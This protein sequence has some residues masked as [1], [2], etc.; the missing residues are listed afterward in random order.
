[1]ARRLSQ[2]MLSSHG[3]IRG[4][5]PWGGGGVLGWGTENVHVP[6]MFTTGSADTTVK[7]EA[8]KQAFQ[9]CRR[10]EFPW[11]SI[12]AM[13]KH[14]HARFG[15][16]TRVW[17]RREKNRFN[18]S[19]DRRRLKIVAQCFGCNACISA[20]QNAIFSGYHMVSFSHVA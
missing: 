10:A 8:V 20:Q 9:A 5:H 18:G 15:I 3:A 14:T 4:P 6:S 16:G 17:R 2:A 19:V 13:H 12:A 7:P 1:M 11:Q